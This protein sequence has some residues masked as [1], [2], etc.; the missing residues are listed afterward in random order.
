MSPIRISRLENAM[1]IVL[2][3]HAA[4]N[5]HDIPGMMR[6]L[7]DHCVLETADP[8]PERSGH[9]GKQAIASY[10]MEYFH[11][12]PNAAIEMEEIFSAG[13]RVALRWKTVRVGP[14]GD[15]ITLRGVDIFRVE[16][17]AIC[18]ILSYVKG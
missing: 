17:G 18:E 8:K 5:K 4:F 11:V 3:Y 14:T 2:D 13:F 9:N 16:E 7:S 10:W 6:L 12:N 15:S 1:R